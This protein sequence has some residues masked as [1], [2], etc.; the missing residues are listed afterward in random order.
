MCMWIFTFY[1]NFT[2]I[3]MFFLLSTVGWHRRA[4]RCRQ[5][6]PHLCSV[7]AGR[8]GGKHNDWWFSNFWDWSAHPATENVHHPTGA[9][10]KLP[11]VSAVVSWRLKPYSP[12]VEMKRDYITTWGN[13]STLSVMMSAHDWEMADERWTWLLC[14]PPPPLFLYA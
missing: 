6:L 7:P 13:N 9:L 14:P 1:M 10:L 12:K 11:L 3:E 5:K 8:T 2:A 4:D